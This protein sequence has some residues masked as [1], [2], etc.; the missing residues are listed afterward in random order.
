GHSDVVGGAVVAASATLREQLGWWANCLGVTGTPFDAFLTLRG[1]RTLSARMR[2]HEDNAAAIVQ[3]L[4]DHPAVAQVYYPGLAS[5]PQH[6]LAR[7]QQQGF[8]AII[9]FELQGGLA[10]VAACL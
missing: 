4:T 7:Q 6:A 3:L 5:H 1:V 10:A 2:I 8:G 9:S